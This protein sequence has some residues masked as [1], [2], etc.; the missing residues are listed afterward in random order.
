MSDGKTRNLA[1][2]FFTQRDNTYVWQKPDRNGSK[3]PMAWQTCN[4][5][6]LCMILHYWGITKETPNEMI[7]RIYDNQEWLRNEG[8][9][10]ALESWENLRKIAEFYIKEHTGGNSLSGGR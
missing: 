6:C 4:I 9:Q 7:E 3:Y 5:T 8:G 2:P 1:V 10:V